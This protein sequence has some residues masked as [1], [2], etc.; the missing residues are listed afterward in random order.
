MVLG[1]ILL[2]EKGNFTP[3]FVNLHSEQKCEAFFLQDRPS[4]RIM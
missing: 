2:P 3:R 1:L 4:L